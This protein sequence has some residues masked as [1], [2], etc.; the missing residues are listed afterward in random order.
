M[1]SAHESNEISRICAL[2]VG[3]FKKN[4]EKMLFPLDNVTETSYIYIISKQQLEKN[5]DLLN[6]IKSKVIKDEENNITSSFTIYSSDHDQSFFYSLKL[7][8]FI[9]EIEKK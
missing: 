4:E 5:K 9:Q 2:S 6:Q 7:T 1:G 3:E 8:H